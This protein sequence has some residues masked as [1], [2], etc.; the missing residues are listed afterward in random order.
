M[1][2]AS[3]G[4]S[5]PI[6]GPGP[7]EGSRFTRGRCLARGN[8]AKTYTMTWGGD[9]E[10]TRYCLKAQDADVNDF[11]E[12]ELAHNHVREM[13]C[14]AMLMRSPSF[15]RFV[16]PHCAWIGRDER[17]IPR[18]YTC[19]D[20]EIGSLVDVLN[21]QCL[22]RP[23]KDLQPAQMLVD[24]A[25]CLA[26]CHEAGVL[27]RDIKPD[28]FLVSADGSLK[29]SD[30]GIS[31]PDVS[32]AV[33]G[34][35]ELFMSGVAHAS[36][37]RPVELFVG[38]MH[39]R[40]TGP[41]ADVY[42]L[43]CSMWFVLT[44]EHLGRQ[45]GIPSARNETM[46]KAMANREKSIRSLVLS[47]GITDRA[48]KKCRRDARDLSLST[49][50][51][52]LLDVMRYSDEGINQMRTKQVLESCATCWGIDERDVMGMV[53][54][55]LCE[56]LSPDPTRRPSARSLVT[57]L[58]TALTGC[59]LR[60][61]GVPGKR[62]VCVVPPGHE[63]S[64]ETTNRI[65]PEPRFVVSF[66]KTTG[67]RWP[68]MGSA[69]T[70]L[71]TD[72]SGKIWNGIKRI[73][74]A[75]A[76]SFRSINGSLVQVLMTACQ[77]Y[78]GCC[79]FSELCTPRSC[80]TLVATL[81]KRSRLGLESEMTTV[82]EISILKACEG[83]LVDPDPSTN[84]WLLSWEEL[85]SDLTGENILAQLKR[86][87]VQ[88][89][90]GTCLGDSRET[91]RLL[92]ERHAAAVA[93]RRGVVRRRCSSARRQRRRH[94]SGASGRGAGVPDGPSRRR[95]SGGRGAGGDEGHGDPEVLPPA[96]GGEG[97]ADAVAGAGAPREAGGDM[98][99]EETRFGFQSPKF[100]P[101]PRN[102][103]KDQD[104]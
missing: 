7:A 17:D 84:W 95:P 3:A 1:E 79:A 14:H 20:L 100:W 27:H 53:L 10:G 43:A 28:N 58:R 96:Q 63:C 25:E 6:R 78:V 65:L 18:A 61:E 33:S 67:S 77:L 19:M 31:Y 73:Y 40:D 69:V 59:D 56:C 35:P 60:A 104:A 2:N 15:W 75:C 55:V 87:Y 38:M 92:E 23:E 80:L 26:A 41:A 8:Y 99:P 45:L 62:S 74:R 102:R 13:C 50:V 46:S 42:A 21:D 5:D 83:C 52:H 32:F 49:G 68:L 94:F 57:K 30:F 54:P 81:I 98:G 71:R 48:A 36:W 29:L 72:K 4:G 86:R 9:L 89:F 76:R 101:P 11:E 64:K 103:V 70:S 22:H 44:R 34:D 37:Y 12:P 66:P 16:Q 47:F 85:K 90:N 93:R 24:M 91:R 97:H 88:C 39:G 51:L 82:E